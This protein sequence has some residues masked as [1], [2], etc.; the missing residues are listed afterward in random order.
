MRKDPFFTDFG[1]K[2]KVAAG[3]EEEEVRGLWLIVDGGYHKWRATQ[4][5]LADPMYPA[6]AAWREQMESVRKDIEGVFGRI[7][8]RFRILKTPLTFRKKSHI[9]NLFMTCVGLHNMLLE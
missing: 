3:A 7:K 8:N 5:A 4:C 6:C 9:D 2:V 1:F